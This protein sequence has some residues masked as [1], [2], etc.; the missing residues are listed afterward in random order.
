MPDQSPAGR[1]ATVFRIDKYVVPSDA[2]PAFI[3][4]AQRIQKTVRPLPGCQR[5]SVLTQTGG[6]G[7]FNVV[8]M[9]E[10][11]NEHAMAD[12]IV[13]MQK[14]LTDEGFDPVLFSR[15]LGVRADQGFYRD[16]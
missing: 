5:H 10:W 2:M 3:K 14:Q 15:K 16:V 9:V 7:E 8:V 13:V 1:N 4:Q 11:E 6:A 12:A